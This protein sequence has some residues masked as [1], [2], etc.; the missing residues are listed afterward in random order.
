MRRVSGNLNRVLCGVVMFF[1]QERRDCCLLYKTLGGAATKIDDPRDARMRHH[2][3]HIE[4]ILLDVED[5]AV[6]LFEPR[7]R[8]SNSKPTIGNCRTEDR[9]AGFISRRK[10]AIFGSNFRK[11]ATE[12]VKKLAN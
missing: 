2:I 4:H 3:H 5:E 12:Q 8:N 6:L 9:D 1:L 7:T 11:L 10:N